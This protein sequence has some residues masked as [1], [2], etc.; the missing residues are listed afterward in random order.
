MNQFPRYLVVGVIN[1]ILGY[2]II[3]SCMYL[4]W[5]TPET[6][7]I[8]GY[9]VGIVASYVL[10]RNYTFNS[11]QNRFSE[12]IRFLTVF[13]IAYASNYVVLITLIHRFG[14]HKGMSQILAGLIYVVISYLMN[15]YFVFNIPNDMIHAVKE[16]T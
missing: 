14:I 10:N 1:T 16:E 11:R 13:I 7:N 2:T 12:S 9:A 8:A 3:F 6:S 15:K 5:M 4:A